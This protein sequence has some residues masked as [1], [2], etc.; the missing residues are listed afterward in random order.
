MKDPRAQGSTKSDVFIASD[1]Y[2]FQMLPNSVP[3]CQL[4]KEIAHFSVA[5]LYF[6]IALTCIKMCSFISINAMIYFSVLPYTS[7][8]KPI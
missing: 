3:Q 6:I 2:I 8:F 5:F 7:N 1:Y 4:G